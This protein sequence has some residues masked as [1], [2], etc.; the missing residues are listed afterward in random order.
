MHDTLQFKNREHAGKVLAERL[1]EYAGR[2]DVIVL[3]LPRGGVPVG[4]AVA[5]ALGVEL[6]VLLVRKLGMPG[7]EE[8]AM[9]AIGSGGL[10][11]LQPEIAHMVPAHVIDAVT[12]REER[13]IERRERLYRGNRPQPDLHGRVVLL[14]DDGLATGST[15]R[16]AVAVTRQQQPARVVVAVPVGA[17]DSCDALAPEVDELVAVGMPVMFRAVSQWYKEFDQTSDEEVQDLLATAWSE[18]TRARRPRHEL[19][20]EKP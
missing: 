11:V 17:R 10:R 13:E 6:D 7:Q 14:V 8:Y 3:A 20:K 1:D 5:Q 2:P 18:H 9:G 4:F 15:M 19:H 12:R 16:A